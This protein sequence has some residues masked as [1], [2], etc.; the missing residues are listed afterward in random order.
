[1][2]PPRVWGAASLAASAAL[3][4]IALKKNVDKDRELKFIK[5][6][7]TFITFITLSRVIMGASQFSI[8]CG[9]TSVKIPQKIEKANTKKHVA[10]QSG[11]VHSTTKQPALSFA[12][13]PGAGRSNAG[14]KRRTKWD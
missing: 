7:R 12:F 13:A 5:V 3:E 6:Y 4:H 9:W 1:M 8:F 10:K 11:Q 2:P 14:C